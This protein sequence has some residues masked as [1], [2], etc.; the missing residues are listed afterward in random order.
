MAWVGCLMIYGRMG[1]YQSFRDKILGTEEERGQLELAT[2]AK[3]T[4][5]TVT[6]RRIMQV[7]YIVSCCTYSNWCLTF[8]TVSM[9][10]YSVN[11]VQIVI[12]H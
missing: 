10:P 2:A 4:S 1:Q 8:L 5:P 6:I 3:P 9:Y 7:S 12:I 11:R